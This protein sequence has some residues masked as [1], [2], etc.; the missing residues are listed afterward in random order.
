M[1][2]IEPVI[3][4]ITILGI[5]GGSENGNYLISA[6]YFKNKGVL[7]GNDFERVSLRVNTEARKGRLTV[8]EN[9]CNE[10]Y[11]W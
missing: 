5:S 2:L 11:G 3:H 4:R 6:S 1:L 10:Q 7:I 9:I 8:G